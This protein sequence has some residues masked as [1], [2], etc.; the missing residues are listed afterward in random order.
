MEK[1][2]TPHAKIVFM[3]QKAFSIFVLGLISPYP[4]VVIVTKE[5]YKEFIYLDNI[6]KINLKIKKYYLVSQFFSLI[7]KATN[8]VF[9]SPCS[10]S[11]KA[12]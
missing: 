3:I 2:K 11:R 1:A 7:P 8:Q 6:K 10:N 4:T 9:F 12:M 5:K